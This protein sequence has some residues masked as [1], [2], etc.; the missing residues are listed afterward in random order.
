VSARWFFNLANTL[1]KH[2]DAIAVIKEGRQAKRRTNRR[3]RHQAKAELREST[4]EK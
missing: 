1:S 4:E 3:A 2:S